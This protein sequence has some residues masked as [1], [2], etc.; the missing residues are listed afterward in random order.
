MADIIEI[1]LR[2]KRFCRPNEPDVD[3]MKPLPYQTLIVKQVIEEVAGVKSFVFQ[4]NSIGY[5]AGQYLT[6]VQNSYGEEIRR[7]Y[8]ITSAPVLNEPLSICVKRV[9]NGAISRMLIDDIV[10]G[11]VL[12]ISGVGGFFTLPS[13]L[14][15]YKEIFFLA[16]GVGITPIYSLLKTVLY[17]HPHL[18]VILIYSNRSQATSIFYKKF[19]ELE[20]KFTA[21]F[22]NIFIESTNKDL[23]QAH[24][25]KELL[26]T[27]VNAHTIAPLNQ[28]L[29][30]ICGPESYMRMCTYTLQE[31]HVP[32]ENIR[33]ENF[34][35]HRSN[36]VPEPPDKDP[37]SVKIFYRGEINSIEAAYPDTI[38][39]S[40]RKQGLVL[41]YSC[42]AGRCGNCAAICKEGRVWMAYNEVLTDEELKKGW[43]LTCTGYPVG[44]DI[45]LGIPE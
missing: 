23:L 19:K 40:A 27:F 41:P 14:A 6:L 25:H 2:P 31:A 20:Q 37:H 45:S 34:N 36:V 10:P 13:D 12:S 3:N 39:K 7:S 1:Y 11:D 33:R 43:V 18:S 42:E 26:M 21:R 35:T 4:E 16:A 9:A 24:L 38:L 30:Y 5:K 32:K 17:Q 29:F 22:R 44:G 28:A 15:S 8:S